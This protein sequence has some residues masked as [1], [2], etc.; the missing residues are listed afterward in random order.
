[1]PRPKG[2]KNKPKI[3]QCDTKPIEPKIED[4]K[5]KRKRRT[6]KEIERDTFIET[7]NLVVDKSKQKSLSKSMSKLSIGKILFR[8]GSY[9]VT[10]SDAL[11]LELWYEKN[12]KHIFIGFYP[13]T[14]KGFQDLI[15][16]IAFKLIMQED[17]ASS[18]GLISTNQVLKALDTF[19]VFIDSKFK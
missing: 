4:P 5:P 9:V 1:M 19:R 6:K 14:L 16:V 15:T 8:Y 17:E 13:A 7:R 18:K 11:N 2:S 12:K 3:P 10:K